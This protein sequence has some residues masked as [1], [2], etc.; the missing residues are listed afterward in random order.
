MQFNVMPSGRT[1]G[2]EEHEE[3]ESMWLS[4]Q[5]YTTRIGEEKT[6]F[7]SNLQLIVLM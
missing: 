4:P 2:I 7:K 3:E 1:L 5:E 6:K